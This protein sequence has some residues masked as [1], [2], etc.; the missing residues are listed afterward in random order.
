MCLNV[1]FS[2]NLSLFRYGLFSFLFVLFSN[3]KKEKIMQNLNI[4]M[5]GIA[6]LGGK[7]ARLNEG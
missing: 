2:A 3:I 7:E 5:V 1:D 6:Y 4:V